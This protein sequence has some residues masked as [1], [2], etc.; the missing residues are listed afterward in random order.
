LKRPLARL[1]V[2]AAASLLAAILLSG[3]VVGPDYKGPP[4]AAPLAAQAPAFQRAG[5][6]SNTVPAG[7]WWTALNDA[8]L[9]RLIDA[10]LADSPDVAEARAR[11]VQSRTGCRRRGP[12][13]PICA[14][15]A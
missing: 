12:P 5:D 11:I 13:P 15:R 9:D 14:R 8:A 1:H 4:L 2:L 10:A 6:L 7:R 3:C